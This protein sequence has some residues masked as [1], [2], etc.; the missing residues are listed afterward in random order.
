MVGIVKDWSIE[1]SGEFFKIELT[2]SASFSKIDDVMILDNL[3]FA[4]INSLDE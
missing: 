3:S 4:E 2:P 1:K